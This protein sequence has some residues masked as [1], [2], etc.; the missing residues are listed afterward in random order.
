MKQLFTLNR[1]LDYVYL[2]IGL[3]LYA[4]SVTV[5][6]LPYQLI[7]GGLTGACAMVFY[8][9]GIP[10][11]YSYFVVN[12][13]LLIIALKVLGRKFVTNTVYGIVMLT[14][15]LNIMQ[16]AVTLPDGSMYQLL[17]EGEY[18][19]SIILGAVLGGVGL[20]I[21]FMNGGSTGGTDIVAAIVNKYREM[22]IGR[23]L[24]LADL[25]IISSSYMIFT[26]WRKIVF[27][28]VLMLLENWIV[29]YVMNNQRESVQ[30]LII[31]KR[32]KDIAHEIGTK[33]GRGITILDGHGWYSGMDMKVLCILAKKREMPA[34]LRLIKAIDSN[35]F[36]SVGSV[37]G[38]FGEGFD[39]IKLKAHQAEQKSL[40][41]QPQ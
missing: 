33:V 28:L 5:F 16:D 15:I 35:A 37:K 6:I 4:T 24:M 8:A 26:D 30:F 34:I 23:V 7:T 31:S 12:C 29:D 36:V 18:F 25:I 38:V 1:T 40:E 22:S 27:G 41:Q 3:I 17:G 13:V 39:P 14:F 10:V 9:T 20:A 11:G 32:Y 21:V 2:T 19:M